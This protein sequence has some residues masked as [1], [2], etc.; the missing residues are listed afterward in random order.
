MPLNKK[1]QATIFDDALDF[2]TLKS[3]M[4]AKSEQRAWIITK[5]AC[6][7]TTLSWLA[8]VLL[9]PL[10]T[11][12]PY[13]VTVDKNSGQTQVVSVLNQKTETMTEQEAI[14]R[15]WLSNYI[16]WREVYDWYTLQSDY[17]NTTAF[18]SPNVQAEYA[19]IY[20]G[21]NARDTIWGKKIKAT[22]KILS[23]VPDDQDQIATIRFEKTIKNVEEKGIGKTSVWVATITS[24]YIPDKA[25]TEQERLVNPLA[26]EVT[27]YRVFPELVR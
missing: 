21:D 24:R 5:T 25:L 22:V 16:R 10:K 11:V 1:S 19:S 27:S 3:V 7:L 14:D 12:E 13:V 6:V 2:E 4:A 9:I 15:Y 20:E 8:L 23:I 26:F 17:N 18:S